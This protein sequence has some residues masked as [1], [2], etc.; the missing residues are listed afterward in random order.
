[1][2][3]AVIT[4][5]AGQDGSYLTEF[6]LEKGYDVFGVNIRKS[7]NS[8]TE[9]IAHLMGHENF[10]YTEGDLSDPIF[11]SRLIHDAQPH[12]FY[13]LGAAS[14]VGY[15]FANPVKVFQVNAEAVI[16]HLSLLKD[17]SP[18]TRYYQ[19]STSE[20][21]GGVDCPAEGYNEDSPMKPRSPYAISKCAAHMA[22]NNYREAYGLFAV[23]GILFN[24]SSLRRGKSFAARK[25]THGI[26]SIKLGLQDTLKMG[27]LSAFRDE[28]CSKDYVK[29]M[30][31]ML[32]QETPKDYVIATGSGA[33]IGE[34]FRYVCYLANLE[35]EEAYELDE[36]FLRPSDVPYLLG[37]ASRAQNELGWKP[38]YDWKRLLKEMYENDLKELR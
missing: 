17:H 2:L 9:N 32:Q 37:D 8:G 33:T 36:R 22:I 14:H 20:M 13:N 19:A 24:H 1:M 27:D 35:F 30:W 25:I 23:S 5:V 11:I 12:E 4:G 38:E 26:A 15:S 28:G 34:M 31:L 10:H 18:A 6:L 21:L 16:M 29:A 3:T 7:V